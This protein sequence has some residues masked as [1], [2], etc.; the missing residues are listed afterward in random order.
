M[1]PLCVLLVKLAV[2]SVASVRVAVES[3]SSSGVVVGGWWGNSRRHAACASA[4]VMF[5]VAGL[6]VCDGV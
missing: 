1:L 5:V 2:D 3:L 6:C 4:K